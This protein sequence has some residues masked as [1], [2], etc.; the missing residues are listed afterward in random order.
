MRFSAILSFRVDEFDTTT[1]A[2][3]FDITIDA[4][5]VVG[6]FG[7]LLVGVVIPSL[8]VRNTEGNNSPSEQYRSEPQQ[9]TPASF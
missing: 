8:V 4:L 2:L 3:E 5:V 7:L 9:R 6:G 1:D